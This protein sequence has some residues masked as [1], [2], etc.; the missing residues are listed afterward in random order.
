M[1][2]DYGKGFKD[3]FLAGFEAGKNLS[4]PQ[5]GWPSTTPNI[6]YRETCPKCGVRIDKPMGYVCS[7]P[8]CPT[9]PNVTSTAVRGAVGSD[10]NYPYPPGANGLSGSMYDGPEY[11]NKVWINGV[12]AELGN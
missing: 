6:S 12:W 3:G 5:I 11:A 1:S 9:F 4:T 8:H 7:S 2:E 10:V